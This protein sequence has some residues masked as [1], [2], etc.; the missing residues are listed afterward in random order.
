MSPVLGIFASG[1]TNSKLGSYESIQT[2]TVGSGGASSITFSSIPSTYKHLQIRAIGRD[3]RAS[4][5]SNLY[6]Q[7]NSDSGANYTGHNFY[8]NGSAATAGFDGASQTSASMMRVSTTTIGSNIFSAGIIDI[9]DYSN[10]NKYKT[11]RS[12]SGFDDNGVSGGQVYFWSGLWMNSASAISTITITPV[13]TP[14]QQYS[15]FALYGIKG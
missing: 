15:S 7:F 5:A 10:T 6:M 11:F 13:T 8:G 3:N 4:S 2:V 9:L 12:L 14:I 1:I